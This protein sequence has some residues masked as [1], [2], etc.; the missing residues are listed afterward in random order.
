MIPDYFCLRMAQFMLKKYVSLILGL[1]LIF[2]FS[3]SFALSQDF[4]QWIAL[5]VQQKYK[6]SPWRSFVYSQL[7]FVDDHN[8]WE[9]VVLEG[10]LGYQLAKPHSVWVG[11]RW[12]GR[13]PY[14][15]FTQENRLFQQYIFQKD[16]AP[17]Y[18]FLSRTRLEEITRSNS[19]QLGLRIRQRF[20]LGIKHDL[21]KNA[22]PYLYDE[23]FFQ[24]NHPLYLPHTFVGENR[25]FLGFNLYQAGDSWWEI[26]YINQY[27]IRTRQQTENQ[28]NHII[29]V[30]YNIP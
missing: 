9:A 19:S 13:N 24:L 8:P 27:Q 10:G 26:G 6:N 28:M 30:T 12:V 25:L 14:N 18:V 22:H 3:S 5:N 16:Y 20:A 23:V 21:F 11:Y 7:R 4:K 29:T 1:F 15:D 2:L 17:M